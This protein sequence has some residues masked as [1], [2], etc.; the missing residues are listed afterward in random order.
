MNLCHSFRAIHHLLFLRRRT[1]FA[2]MA[3][4]TQWSSFSFLASAKRRLL[5]IGIVAGAS[6]CRLG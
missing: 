5:D 1:I 4:T 2:A 6:H 3:G